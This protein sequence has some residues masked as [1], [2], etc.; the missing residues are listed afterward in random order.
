METKYKSLGA[1]VRDNS[2]EGAQEVLKALNEMKRPT[3]V[4]EWTTL[5]F[6][7]LDTLTPEM[8]QFL[9]DQGADLDA[10][11]SLDGDDG[12]SQVISLGY[13]TVLSNN[14]PLMEWML[15]QGWVD[16]KKMVSPAGDTVLVQAIREHAFDI[17]ELCVQRG[18]SINHQNMRGVSAMHEAASKGDYLVLDWLIERKA[19]PTLETMDGAVPCELVPEISEEPGEADCLFQALDE[20]LADY[21]KLKDSPHLIQPPQFIAMKADAIRAQ[22]APPPDAAAPKKPAMRT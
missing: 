12:R 10:S 20:Y 22:N 14:R 15:E 3:T 7:T 2:L 16:E 18:M 9:K 13:A 6:K 11:L 5:L 19:D 21:K 17:A 1:A 4:E 8:A